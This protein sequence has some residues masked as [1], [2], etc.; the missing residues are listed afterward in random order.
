MIKAIVFD[1]DGTIID[2]ET[3]WFY[4]FRDEYQ[5]HGIELTLE[6]YSKCIGTSLHSF[7]P[8]EYI[9]TV[10]EKPI[11]LKAFGQKVRDQ[12]SEFMGK[13]KIRP[14]IMDYLNK[15]KAAGLKIGLASSSHREWIDTYLDQLNLRSYFECI[16]TG[17]QV[18]KVKPDPAL[19]LQTLKCLGVE[20]HEAIAVEDSPN[21]ARAA[22]A[23][24]MHYVV[25]P[26]TITKSLSFDTTQFHASCLGELTFDELLASKKAAGAA[27]N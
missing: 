18:E 24:G 6:Q 1:F 11:D 12:H 14:G 26:N 22:A 5:K 27:S 7:N 25:C 3:A 20:P 23:A 13:E 17:D 4:A 19:Y 8:Y 21:G 15:A 9:N 16:R 10:L 2:T